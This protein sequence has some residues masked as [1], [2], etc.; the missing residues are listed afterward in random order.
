[1]RYIYIS[2]KDQAKLVI[3]L[4]TPRDDE[5]SF[6]ERL[7]IYTDPLIALALA[8]TKQNDNDFVHLYISKKK[9]IS[10]PYIKENFNVDFQCDASQSYFS[11][12]DPSHLL[13]LELKL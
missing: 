13:Y 12:K 4:V 7:Q 1:M 10:L 5:A 8:Q 6:I 9:L 2:G 3:S 11:F